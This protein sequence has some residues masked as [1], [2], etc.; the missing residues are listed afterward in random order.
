[1]S[2]AIESYATIYNN[3]FI[4]AP[5][6]HVFYDSLIPRPRN[7]LFSYLLLP[8]V[9]Y[10]ESRNFL[11]Y[12]NSRSSLRSLTSRRDCLYGLPRR[13][14]EYKKLTN[15]CLQYTV[16]MGALVVQDDLSVQARDVSLNQSLCPRNSARATRN[17]GQL[18]APFAVPEVYRSLGV[19]AL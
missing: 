13:T 19:Q 5:L 9:L 7:I 4:L 8:L 18:L 11:I 2:N 17:L 1:M 14:E 15:L 16:D 12:A 3:P 10:P 6:F